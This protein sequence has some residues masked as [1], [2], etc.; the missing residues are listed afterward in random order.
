[1]SYT[2]KYGV[3]PDGLFTVSLDA[4]GNR[5]A[6]YVWGHE[7]HRLTLSEKFSD[8]DVAETRFNALCAAY[9]VTEI[10]DTEIDEGAFDFD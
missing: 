5:Y 8:Y 4:E 1:M 3:T 2:I 6:V 10:K 9:S 7:A